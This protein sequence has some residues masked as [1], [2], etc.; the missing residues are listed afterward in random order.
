MK[1]AQDHNHL[2]VIPIGLGDWDGLI[3]NPSA[4]QSYIR[5]FQSNTG[6]A[7]EPEVLIVEGKD[8]T[9]ESLFADCPT[10]PVW[11][12]YASQDDGIQ[13]YWGPYQTLHEL[14][15]SQINWSEIAL[16]DHTYGTEFTRLPEPLNGI[17]S[18]F[19]LSL[20]MYRINGILSTVGK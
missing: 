1:D 16:S 15:Q 11:M 14:C 7:L 10:S 19:S 5:K 12:L 17:Y 13:R 18:R 8:F 4:V 6:A 20:L 3:E 9:T 2:L